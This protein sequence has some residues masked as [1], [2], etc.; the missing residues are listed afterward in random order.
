M[1]RR[2]HPYLILGLALHGR[3]AH[4]QNIER[5][6]E[7]FEEASSLREA[8]MYADAAARLRQAIA[9]KDTP[10]LQYHAGYCESKLGHFRLAVRYYERAATLLR[11]G[12]AAPDVSSLLPAAHAA[13]LREA[14][15]IRI[16]LT[17]AVPSPRLVL[18]DEGEQ[19][20]PDDELVVDPGT[21]HLAVSAAGYKSEDRQIS[22]ARGEALR[23]DVQ[24]TPVSPTARTVE[25]E[26]MDGFPWK[27]LSV[28]LG[29]GVTAT[30]ITLGIVSA[31]QRHNAQGRIALYDGIAALCTTAASNCTQAQQ[32]Q[33]LMD[34]AKASS[35]KDSATRWEVVGFASAGVGAAATIA[36]WSLW[37]SSRDVSVALS[38][39]GGQFAASYLAFTRGF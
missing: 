1:M 28:G 34:L 7:L 17:P 22:V 29:L 14:A 18:D 12:V 6:K 33:T 38:A 27:T 36:L 5:A 31:T 30:G 13:A 2:L 24:L 10:G 39:Q 21:H 11:E 19:A 16:V 35:D 9:I 8:G 37:P 23:L 3:S 32:Q 25:S 26:T 4:A 20:M 15:R